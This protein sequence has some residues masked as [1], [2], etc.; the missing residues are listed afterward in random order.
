MRQFEGSG[1]DYDAVLV[2]DQLNNSYTAGSFSE[3]CDFDPGP[4]SSLLTSLGSSDIFICKQDDSGNL[5]WV[6][7]IGNTSEDRVLDISIDQSGNIF[8]TGYF[9][10]TVDFDPGPGTDFLTSVG[11]YDGY[12]LKLNSAGDFIWVKQFGGFATESVSGCSI[13]A[14]GNIYCA[15]VFTGFADLDPGISTF[16]VTSASSAPDVFLVKLNSDGDFLY[17]KQIGGT[18]IDNVQSIRTDA[19]DNFYISGSFEFSVDFDPG[20]GIY[21]LTSEGFMDCYVSKFDQAGNLMWVNHFGGDAMDQIVSM[22]ISSDAIYCT[23]SFN[24]TVDFDPGTG[25]S[26]NNSD[27]SYDVFISKFNLAGN[28]IWSK[29]FGGTGNDYSLC[30][31]VDDFGNIYTTGGFSNSADFLPGSGTFVLT[32]DGDYDIFISAIDVNG[33]FLW[34]RKIGGADAEWGRSITTDLNQDI[35]FTGYFSSTPAD[36]DTGPGSYLLSSSN[37]AD[38]FIEKLDGSSLA[39][40]ISGHS[41]T[42]PLI[43]PNPSSGLFYFHNSKE[44]TDLYFTVYTTDGRIV[45]LGIINETNQYIDLSSQ[46]KGIYLIQ[47]TTAQS[48]QFWTKAVIE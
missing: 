12:L 31:V 4:G 47:F 46:N 22:D 20:A 33:N 1:S 14:A 28:F 38:I 6:K 25:S 44:G 34:A 17:G 5:I 21:N 7:Q 18:G 32:S 48:E 2:I 41:E 40:N 24:D 35:R 10:G 37:L 30:L 39:I 9:T 36:F 27:G 42:Q 15:G 45:S 43:S 16:S 26:S 13:D 8:V 23:G 29:Q 3:T 19:S 11:A